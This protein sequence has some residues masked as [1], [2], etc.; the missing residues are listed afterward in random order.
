M[1]DIDDIDTESVCR[2]LEGQS[3]PCGRFEEQVT[4]DLPVER[5]FGLSPLA[6][7]TMVSA[8]SMMYSMSFLEKSL[9]E[10]TSLSKKLTLLLMIG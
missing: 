10:T 7:G 1:G 8:R 6:Y 9:M 5:V 4:E 2:A 3:G